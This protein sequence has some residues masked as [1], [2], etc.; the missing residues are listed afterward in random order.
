MF[1]SRDPHVSAETALQACVSL[2][3]QLYTNMP[4]PLFCLTQ[5]CGSPTRLPTGIPAGG[6]NSET[7]RQRCHP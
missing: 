1:A 7:E 5:F 6:H 4:F 3:Q 2:L